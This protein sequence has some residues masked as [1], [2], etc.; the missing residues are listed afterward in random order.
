MQRLLLLPAQLECHVRFL[1][2]PLIDTAE[3]LI[4]SFPTI[5]NLLRSLMYG[6]R[7][8]SRA[9]AEKPI[10]ASVINKGCQL[11]SLETSI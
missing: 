4:V 11:N 2:Q 1:C 6:E 8:A 3:W 7:Y 10:Q 9:S 5:P